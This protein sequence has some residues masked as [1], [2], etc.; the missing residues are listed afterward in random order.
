MSR[1]PSPRLL[2]LPWLLMGALWAEG[3]AGFH[4]TRVGTLEITAL[5]DGEMQLPPSLLKSIAAEDLERMLGGKEGVPT[6]VNAFLVRTGQHLVLVDAGKNAAMDPSMGH[7]LA[8]LKEAW[9]DPAAIEAVLLTHLHGDHVGGLITADG[10]RA[11]PNAVVRVA[12]AEH[13]YWMGTALPKSYGPMI[14]MIKAALAPYQEAGAYKPFTPQETPFPGVKA[15][16]AP[17]H[18]PGHTVYAFGQGAHTFWA[19]GDLVHFGKVQFQRPEATVTF[20]TNQPQAAK[21]RLACWTL[22]AQKGIVLGGAHLAFPGLG[23]VRAT[24]KAFAWAPLP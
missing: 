21:A 12:Q 17:G 2:L 10:R 9:V 22:A 6:P 23:Q 3:P 1:I 24:G 15:I 16:S 13:D 18:T 19:I 20:D 14:A 7:I 11:F 4:R 8:R 5:L